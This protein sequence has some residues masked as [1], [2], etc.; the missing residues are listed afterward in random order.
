[1]GSDRLQVELKDYEDSSLNFDKRMCM[2]SAEP[3]KTSKFKFV[4]ILVERPENENETD[5]PFKG[6]GG[7]ALCVKNA[8]A[9]LNE[10]EGFINTDKPGEY[11]KEFERT[12]K[13]KDEFIFN[14]Y[15]YKG[16][17]VKDYEEFEEGEPI[18]ECSIC[19]NMVFVEDE[20][21]S[22]QDAG[23]KPLVQCAPFHRGCLPEFIEIIEDVLQDE[24]TFTSVI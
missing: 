23:G 11:S 19:E 14:K 3:E 15:I 22:L 9:F 18:S 13:I 6:G 4:E 7:G 10:L 17:G 2:F 12:E 21:L 8:R 24:D 5:S 20:L 1:M 16:Q